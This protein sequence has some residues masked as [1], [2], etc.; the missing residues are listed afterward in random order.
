MIALLASVLAASLI[1]S[2]HCAGMCGGMAAFCGGAGQCSGRASALASAIYHAGRLV[3]YVAVG[4]AAGVFG[5]LLNRGGALVGVQQMAAIAAGGAVALVGAGMVMQ[6]GG[7]ESGSLPLPAWMKRLLGAVQRAAAAMPPARRA[8]VI[9]LATPLL[10]C[11]W[12]WAFAAV[13]AGT[14]HGAGGAAV[15]AAFWAG[16]VPVLAVLGAGIASIAPQ[17]RRLLAAT[18]GLFMIAVGV[19][20]AGVRAPLAPLVADRLHDRAARD[21]ASILAGAVSGDAAS[22]DIAPAAPACCAAQERP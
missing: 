7:V 10:P 9:G 22:A 2:G 15:M 1:G 6:A 11:G 20:T 4:A 17:R 3:S 5:V 21:D 8:L 19:Y 16:T 18:A 14:G 13:A 12:L